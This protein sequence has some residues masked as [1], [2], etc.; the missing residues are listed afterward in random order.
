VGRRGTGTAIA[1]IEASLL[2]SDISD[3]P[4]WQTSYVDRQHRRFSGGGQHK[5][6]ASTNGLISAGG[7]LISTAGRDLYYWRLLYAP[8]NTVKLIIA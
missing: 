8:A 7:W 5:P 6:T 3:P 2:A 4:A 1:S